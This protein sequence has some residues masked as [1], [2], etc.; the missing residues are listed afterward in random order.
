MS[1]ANANAHL[2]DALTDLN[3][4]LADLD[5]GDKFYKMVEDVK[6]RLQYLIDY[7]AGV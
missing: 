4:A 7:T 2:D 6:Q 1:R 3:S 5:A